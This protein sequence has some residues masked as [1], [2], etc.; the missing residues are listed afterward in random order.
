MKQVNQQL[1]ESVNGAYD[2][3]THELSKPQEDVVSI[4]VCGASKNAITNILRLYLDA[5]GVDYSKVL[6]VN[7]LAKM[8]NAQNQKFSS[9]NFGVMNCKCEP[10]EDHSMSYCLGEDSIDACY[11]L[12]SELKD[13]IYEDIGV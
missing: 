1:L 5:K 11:K 12:L 6:T 13:F 8:C 4:S 7:E 9:F 10:T 2:M 3:I